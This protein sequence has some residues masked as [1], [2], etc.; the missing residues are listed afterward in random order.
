MSSVRSKPN[1][2]HYHETDMYMALQ[3]S[4]TLATIHIRNLLGK[5]KK[6]TEEVGWKQKRLTE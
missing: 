5:K 2:A 4:S 6:K 1:G 3:D